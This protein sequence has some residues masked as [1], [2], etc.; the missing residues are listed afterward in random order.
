MVR[1]AVIKQSSL[2]S[3][4]SDLALRYISFGAG[5]QSTALLV[6][7][8]LGLH[9]CPRAHV[10]IFADTQC[11]PGWVYDHLSVMERWS[12]IPILRVTTGN[13]GRRFTA[14]LQGQRRRAASLPV[15]T[16]GADGR[17]APLRRS[18]T[19][20]YKVKPIE[21]KVRELL[22]YQRGQRVKVR[23]GCMLGISTD[24]MQRIRASHVWWSANLYPLIDA[25]MSRA[26][27]IDLIRVHDL[28]VPHRSACVFC[29]YHSDEY[30]RD[31]KE[32][33]PREWR[34]AV[35]FDRRIRDMQRVGIRSS[36]FLH[37]SCLPL[38]TVT[39]A[40]KERPD[41]FRQEC[42]GYCGN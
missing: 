8:N 31:L 3:I 14:W 12:T 27:C 29:P 16:R 35:A 36:A 28:P 34:R 21:R 2:Q 4:D 37:R 25:R 10:A 17:G 30:W 6:M 19:R 23:V 42:L 13:L 15:W 20:D 7:S 33:F 32:R 38:A 26:D 39:L 5:V 40:P 41:E 22:G 18:C 24:E 11:E 9:G 1:P